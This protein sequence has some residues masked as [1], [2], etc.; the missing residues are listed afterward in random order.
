MSFVSLFAGQLR[1]SVLALRMQTTITV[2]TTC[3]L[4]LIMIDVQ[5]TRRRS[6]LFIFRFQHKLTD[7]VKNDFDRYRSFL[8][9]R[10]WVLRSP[11]PPTDAVTGAQCAEYNPERLLR[12]RD[13]DF[14]HENW[15]QAKADFKG[16]IRGACVR[17]YGDEFTSTG[18]CRLRSI[19]TSFPRM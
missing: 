2:V 8:A 6:D 17:E 11:T 19:A 7:H 10:R 16:A 5:V 13:G 1:L 15:A 9:R 12:L 14:G 3:W 18:R 4:R